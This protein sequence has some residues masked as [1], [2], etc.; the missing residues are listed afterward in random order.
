MAVVQYPG[1]RCGK[2]DLTKLS[3]EDY[4]AIGGAV[5]VRASVEE[6]VYTWGSDNVKA[7]FK[8]SNPCVADMCPDWFTAGANMAAAIEVVG[9]LQPAGFPSNSDTEYTSNA[10]ATNHQINATDVT[11]PAKSRVDS[12]AINKFDMFPAA[13]LPCAVAVPLRSNIRPYGPYATSNF[14][15]SCGGIN[16]QVDKDIAPW[17][18]GSVDLMNTAATIRLASME[19]DPL[20]I[21]TTGTVT[22]PCLPELSLGYS[23]LLSGPVLNGLSVNFGAQGISTT[24]SYQ[25]FT[26]KF[27]SF[28]GATIDRIK[29]IAK[30]RREQLKLLR[31]NEILTRKVSR[32]R[33]KVDYGKTVDDTIKRL[34]KQ[35]SLSRVFIGEMNDWWK[36]IN[37]GPTSPPMYGPYFPVLDLI[38][39]NR[40][41]DSE[42]YRSGPSVPA[43]HNAQRTVVGSETL[44]KQVLELRWDYSRKAFM[45]M[46]GLLG[47]ISVSGDGGLP[48]YAKYEPKIHRQ[49]PL[50]PQPPFERCDIQV[51]KSEVNDGFNPEDGTDVPS[52]YYNQKI[53]Q[54]F[55]NPVQNPTISHHHMG[56]SHGHIIDILGRKSRIDKHMSMNLNENQDYAEDYRFLGLR[57]PLVLHSWGYD[58]WG[59]PIPNEADSESSV[60]RGSFTEE[61][62][63][64]RFMSEWLSKP[65]TWP[66]GPVDLRFDRDRGVWVSP[67]QDYKVIVVR[68]VE[69]LVP[70]GTAKAQLINQDNEA[71]KDYGPTLWGFEGESLDATSDG[72]SPYIVNVEDRIKSS[73]K[74][75]TRLYAHYDTYTGKYIVFGHYKEPQETDII[76]FRIYQDQPCYPEGSGVCGEG[77]GGRDKL[78]NHHAYAIRIDCSGNTIDINGNPVGPADIANPSK[79]EEIFVNL[80]D[81]AG[82]HGPA[83]AAYTSYEEWKDKAHT[84]FAAKIFGMPQPVIADSGVVTAVCGSCDDNDQSV[85]IPCS[86]CSMGRSDCNCPE[87]GLPN[88]DILYL[89]GY[90]RFIHAIINEDLY[91]TQNVTTSDT[92]CPSGEQYVCQPCEDVYDCTSGSS[93]AEIIGDL[94]YG[95]SPNGRRPIFFNL[96]GETNFKVFDPFS[97]KPETSPFKDLKAGSKVLTIFNEKEKKYYI[98]QSEVPPHIAK[99]KLSSYDCCGGFKDCEDS[100]DYIDGK[101]PK[102]FGCS[103]PTTENSCFK[104]F[105]SFEDAQYIAYFNEEDKQYQVINAEEA[106][107]LIEGTLDE[108]LNCCD[109]ESLV[110]IT[111]SHTSKQ[112]P[113]IAEKRPIKFLIKEVENPRGFCGFAG[114]EAVIHR[115]RDENCYKYVLLHLGK[116]C[117]YGSVQDSGNLNAECL[118][119]NNAYEFQNVCDYRYFNERIECIPGY[120]ADK[121]Q[122]LSHGKDFGLVWLSADNYQTK[123]IHGSW[124]GET[125]LVRGFSGFDGLNEQDELVVGTY[126]AVENPTTDCPAN[127]CNGQ[128]GVF[129]PPES[130][131]AWATATYMS[132]GI[133]CSWILT[134]AECCNSCD[135]PGC[136]ECVECEL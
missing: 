11:G 133:D 103:Y 38:D 74:C 90:A 93:D 1:A 67:P 33:S 64:D 30:N 35:A 8:F 134:N 76:R 106:P 122:R 37:G 119:S 61:N 82:E 85:D 95:N 92:P 55:E 101:D 105:L 125:I 16:V 127:V 86:G 13:V 108:N 91:D 17:V 36:E 79:K 71:G 12:A 53:D 70:L 3:P 39:G 128:N 115:R 113:D 97:D 123:V 112:S 32:L 63:T 102:E 56:E 23:M 48:Q 20:I 43:K 80:F 24:Y 51:L 135:F 131:T 84:G 81:T 27:G 68:L 129:I 2:L 73:Y 6:K 116:Q 47:P 60:M 58:T 14:H 117:E 40:L 111:I 22:T 15:S 107:V 124:D 99:L 121:T 77:L 57:G 130:G 54:K 98:W 25:T 42:G 75:G 4:I 87:P 83:Y 109:T 89:E 52:S 88:Y 110:K 120:Q 66:V 62:L 126:I 28:S 136:E 72:S 96:N 78:L 18:F 118:L 41:V 7:V 31:N 94:F 132:D 26:P 69:D 45:S 21:G 65:A 46:D 19:T 9:S 10:L 29:L 114:D 59:K 104:P 44:H 5:W 100:C 34:S 49:A 50:S